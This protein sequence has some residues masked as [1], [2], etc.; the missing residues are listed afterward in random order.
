LLCRG[1]ENRRPGHHLLPSIIGL[2]AACRLFN[3]EQA[4]NQK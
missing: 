4:F 2:D 3:I 1:R